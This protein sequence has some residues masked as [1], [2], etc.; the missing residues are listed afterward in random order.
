MRAAGLEANARRLLEALC[1]A[2]RAADRSTIERIAALDGLAGDAIAQGL[3]QLQ[4]EGWLHQGPLLP[5]EHVMRN[6]VRN[7]MPPARAAELHRFTAETLVATGGQGAQAGFGRALVAHHM[8]E[9]GRERE[10][11]PA[12]LDFIGEALSSVDL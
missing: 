3:S 10:A 12:L 4:R 5:I 1:V 11:A 7:G 6:A 2:P 9:G 8:A